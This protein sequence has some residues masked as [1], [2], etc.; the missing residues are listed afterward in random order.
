MLSERNC[1]TFGSVET[2]PNILT[3]SLASRVFIMAFVF[4]Q[5][6]PTLQDDLF[7]AIN[8]IRPNW[9]MDDSMKQEVYATSFPILL[10]LILQEEPSLERE[11]EEI[12]KEAVLQQLSSMQHKFTGV[13]EA[14]GIG[15]PLQIAQLMI[16]EDFISCENLRKSDPSKID[17]KRYESKFCK[18]VI[19]QRPTGLDV[20]DILFKAV[21]RD[22]EMV[23]F[24]EG[25]QIRVFKYLNLIKDVVSAH[26]VANPEKRA[27]YEGMGLI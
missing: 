16:L 11:S 14:R 12:I 25:P 15:D 21:K 18:Y 4:S 17:R 26:T 3:E 23:D 24:R 8:K 10:D 27:L 9:S 20:F 5:S 2:D 22:F 6:D 19:E 13:K 1:A 7:V